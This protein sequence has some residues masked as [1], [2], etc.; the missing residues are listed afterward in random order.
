MS[1]IQKQHKISPA[2]AWLTIQKFII[3]YCPLDGEHTNIRWRYFYALLPVCS[4]SNIQVFFFC[5]LSSRSY[6]ICSLLQ[7]M[8]SLHK[9][10]APKAQA[11]NIMVIKIIIN[12][13]MFTPSIFYLPNNPKPFGCKSEFCI[14]N[15]RLMPA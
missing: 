2:I 6:P 7:F 9:Q 10:K 14:R 3:F 15:D 1:N 12:A 8:D 11:K 4:I 5:R 13:N